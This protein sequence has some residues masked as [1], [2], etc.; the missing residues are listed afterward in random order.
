MVDII[1]TIEEPEEIVVTIDGNNITKFT[2]LIDTPSI[3][4]GQ[5]GKVATVNSTEDAIEFTIPGAMW[6][7]IT[8]TLSSQT[9]LQTELNTKVVG[10]SSSINNSLVTFNSTTGKIVKDS[11]L[12]CENDKIYQEGYPNSYI[13][14]NNGII[15]I[16]ANGV[17][18]AAW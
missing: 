13:K 1:A 16:W 2:Q 11:G 3:Y 8:G 10:P 14:F 17:K 6:G 12:I 15:E 5:A 9:D 7:G 18:Q 4:S